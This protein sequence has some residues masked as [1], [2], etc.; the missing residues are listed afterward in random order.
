MNSNDIRERFSRVT[1]KPGETMD[2]IK[3]PLP[4]AAKIMNMPLKTIYGYLKR[5]L[6]PTRKIPSGPS[7]VLGVD[8]LNEDFNVAVDYNKSKGF[9][10][11][12]DKIKES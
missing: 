7:Y 9:R 10:S 6:L 8:L 1:G 11:K 12:T 5:G 3:L 4:E 2:N